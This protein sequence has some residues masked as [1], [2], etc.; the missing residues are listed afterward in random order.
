MIDC[1][2]L[3]LKKFKTR[4]AAYVFYTAYMCDETFVL[5]SFMSMR[6]AAAVPKN[7]QKRIA[8]IYK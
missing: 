3:Q 6:I 2:C 4:H 7:R 5:C 8:K 1:N